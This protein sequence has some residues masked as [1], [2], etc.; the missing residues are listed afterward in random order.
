MH[1]RRE[2]MHPV[3]LKIPRYVTALNDTSSATEQFSILMNRLFYPNLMLLR[4]NLQGDRML[5][6]LWVAQEAWQTTDACQEWIVEKDAVAAI[7][8]D[9]PASGGQ[10]TRAGVAP[11]LFGAGG[12]HHL[13]AR[14]LT[15]ARSALCTTTLPV[16]IVSSVVFEAWRHL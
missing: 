3:G 2:Q 15:T 9:R 11:S 10:G 7:Q 13:A 5:Q 16:I 12:L 4:W 8:S 1:V 6:S 14:Q